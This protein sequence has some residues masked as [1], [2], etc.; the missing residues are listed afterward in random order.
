MLTVIIPTL[1][2]VATLP[3]LLGRLKGVANEVVVTDGGSTDSTLNIA[4]AGGARLCVGG[5]GRGLQLS[6]AAGFCRAQNPNDW[7]LILHADSI[8]PD[9]F[10]AAVSAHMAD[11]PDRAGYFRFALDD[12][13]PWPRV[14]ESLVKDR[15]WWFGLP[16]GDQ[17]LLVRRDVY[18]S[19]GGYPEWPLFEDVKIVRRLGRARMRLIDLPI[20]TSAARYKRDGYKARTF[21][22]L[23]LLLRFLMTGKPDGLA[24]KY[25]AER[26][27]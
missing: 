19:V 22:N 13:G 27:K 23:G 24:E 1:N 5:A 15:C 9:G 14:V 26:Y 7:L 21:K 10:G 12:T 6:R 3:G 18:R 4:I 20:T 17:G 25:L 2:A 8:L 11:Y 16:Y